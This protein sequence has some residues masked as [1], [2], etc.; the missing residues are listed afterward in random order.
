MRALITLGMV[1]FT[2]M[3]WCCSDLSS[4]ENGEPLR[5]IF[6][7]DF[8]SD[9]DDV[10][11][12]A[13]LHALAD[14]GEV[15]ILAMGVSSKHAWSVPCLDVLNTYFGRPD[16]PMGV[17]RGDGV[18]TGS[19]YCETVANEFPHDSKSPEQ[20]P[21]A[22]T[23]YRR[24]LAAQPDQ[25]V[26]IVS[27]GFLTNLSNLLK[28]KPDENSPLNGTELVRRKIRTWVAMGV[29]HPTGRE[30]NIRKDPSSAVHAVAGW[31]T[32]IVWTGYEIGVEILTGARLRELPTDSPVRRCYELY[33]G[34]NNRKSWDQTAVLYAVRGLAGRL[35]DFWYVGSGGYYHID[36]D[37]SN[38]W[39]PS[40]HGD[41]SY[42]IKKMPAGD[43]A[44]A[45]E[46]PMLHIPSHIQ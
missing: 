24:I 35:A 1:I 15:N 25:S 31:P 34:I 9:A 20:I 5:L 46:N 36:T 30:W 21:A 14:R 26:V 29:K 39:R 18:E 11:A 23:L 13:V 38:T 33:N 3:M 41:H 42:L 28:T 2:A 43:V 19:S 6:D 32:P 4:A 40:P 8:E 37:G 27:V 16:I 10:G 22:P 45:I 44:R 17:V 12:V 7:T